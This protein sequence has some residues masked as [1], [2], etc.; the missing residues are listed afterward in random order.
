MAPSA[1]ETNGPQAL[2]PVPR[3]AVDGLKGLR[4][5]II[6]GFTQAGRTGVT[7]PVG[8]LPLR[9]DADGLKASAVA[10]ALTEFEVL[11]Q[12]REKNVG[13]LARLIWTVTIGLTPKAA[14]KVEQSCVPLA[15]PAAYV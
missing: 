12:M 14:G 4:F 5:G 3:H 1:V 13:K 7:V 10:F 9:S 2:N 15:P 6:N 11:P 8:P